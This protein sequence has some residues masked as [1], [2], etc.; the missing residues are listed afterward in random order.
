MFNPALR[1]MLRLLQTIATTPVVITA[2]LKVLV[3]T[4]VDIYKGSH[5]D[6]EQ[7]IGLDS[8]KVALDSEINDQNRFK[9]SQVISLKHLPTNSKYFDLR[10][11]LMIILNFM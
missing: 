3:V 10:S 7:F 2:T 6:N 11:E 4:L 1:N 5:F 8:I 9:W